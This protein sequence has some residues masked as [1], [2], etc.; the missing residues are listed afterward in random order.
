MTRGYPVLL[1]IFMALGSTP[2]AAQNSTLEECF[3]NS[4]SSADC[5]YRDERE[6]GLRGRNPVGPLTRIAANHFLSQQFQQAD[7]ALN[8][9]WEAV[10][11]KEGLFTRSQVPLLIMQAVNF[12]NSANWVE[13]RKLQN[14]L[15]W[16]FRSKFAVPDR[17]MIDE[18]RAMSRL[19]MRGVDQDE[20]P[21]RAYH[22][23]RAL[24]SNRLAINVANAIWPANDERKA[25]LI[26]E[27]L[28]M[29]YMRASEA[30]NK[31]L[32]ASASSGEGSFPGKLVLNLAEKLTLMDMRKAGDRYL[33]EFRQLLDDES[34]KAL[35]HLGIVKLYE[36]DWLLLF[37]R[38]ADVNDLY[39]ESRKLLEQ[40]GVPGATVDELM[41]QPLLQPGMDY[42]AD[43]EQILRARSR[44][45]NGNMPAP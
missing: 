13:A 15:I 18:L 23:V 1:A 20:E 35:E 21:Y 4:Q 12:A 31:G 19:H 36:A 44:Q 32:L 25:E 8:L 26:H 22:Y 39:I 2:L 42:F 38:N 30:M 17:S 6:S 28:H 27:Q 10:R 40:A 3:P 37:D 43:A 45:A 9:A 34:S 33:E 5:L 16:L 7:E 41:D 14:H 11:I 24:Y 29:L